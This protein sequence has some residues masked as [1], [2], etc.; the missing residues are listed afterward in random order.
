MGKKHKYQIPNSKEIGG[1]S[2]KIGNF[3]QS[4]RG[5]SLIEMLVVLAVFSILAVV[6]SQVLIISLRSARKSESVVVVKQN[7]DYAISTI[8]RLLRNAQDITFCS[9]GGTS[10][11]D[12]I[13]ENNK[14]GRF[15][16]TCAGSDCYIASGSASPVRITSDDVTITNCGSVFTCPVPAPNVA[17]SV[18]INL[19][20]KHSGLGT[21]VE[22]AEVTAK[23]KILLRTF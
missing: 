19:K 2:L 5:F 12:Y 15:R 20:A 22:G 9:P 7:V 10:Q 18:I 17:E 4:G 8:E 14:A 1:L 16:C 13:D 3:P 11:L 21:G 6:A 23:S